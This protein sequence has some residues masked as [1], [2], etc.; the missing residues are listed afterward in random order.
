MKN[1]ILVYLREDVTLI[2]EVESNHDYNYQFLEDSRKQ[3]EKLSFIFQLVIH[4]HFHP[5]HNT[6]LVNSFSALI[7]QLLIKMAHYF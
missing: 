7:Y 4:F 6:M 5:S 1:I 3:L 2:C